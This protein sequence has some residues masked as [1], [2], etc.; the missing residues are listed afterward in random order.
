MFSGFSELGDLIDRKALM[1]DRV[2][3]VNGPDYKGNCKL[4]IKMMD[5]FAAERL[6][7]GR[8]VQEIM[9]E[10]RRVM[11]TVLSSTGLRRMVKVIDGHYLMSAI[12]ALQ[13]EFRLT[14]PEAKLALSLVQLSTKRLLISPAE[15]TTVTVVD[16]EE[17]VPA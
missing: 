17:L 13:Q 3:G 5:A 1:L 7:E 2:A 16:D 12:G 14:F 4:L 9:V 6:K 8:S 10:I 11:Q 15:E